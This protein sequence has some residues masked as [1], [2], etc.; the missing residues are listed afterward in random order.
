MDLVLS[1]IYRTSDTAE[2][3]LA[4]AYNAEPHGLERLRIPPRLQ[5]G[6]TLLAPF[7]DGHITEGATAV[8]HV[9]RA[10]NVLIS[11]DPQTGG[12]PN[13]GVETEIPSELGMAVRS[14]DEVV[15]YL[16]RLHSGIV[17]DAKKLQDTI[18]AEHLRQRKIA[19]REK[20]IRLGHFIGSFDES[21]RYLWLIVNPPAQDTAPNLLTNFDTRTSVKIARLVGIA[22]YWVGNKVYADPVVMGKYRT[23]GKIV[24]SKYKPRH[25]YLYI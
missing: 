4:T 1:G 15:K 14:I 2:F 17:D 7:S 22:P 9:P 10:I 16:S 11:K 20:V 25:N 6:T 21:G 23:I 13:T 19:T 24:T 5:T 12:L 3:P 8:R 18:N